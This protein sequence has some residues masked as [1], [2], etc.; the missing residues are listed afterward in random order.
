MKQPA[1]PKDSAAEEFDT[2]DSLEKAVHGNDWRTLNP[3]Q[4]GEGNFVDPV[5]VSYL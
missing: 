2:Q 1:S 5:T 3:A 4:I